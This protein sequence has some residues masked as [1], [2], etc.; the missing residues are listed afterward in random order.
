MQVIP[1]VDVLDGAV[2][3]LERGDFERVTRYS[4]DAVEVAR[5][6]VEEGAEVVHVVDLA[7]ARTGRPSAGLWEA[8]GAANL[9]FQAAG[10]I[11]TAEAARRAL[12]AGAVRIVAGTTAV[13]DDA[14]LGE[15]AAAAGPAL[16]V[17]LDVRDGRAFGAGWEDP[18]REAEVVIRS[19]VQA[20]AARVMVTGIAADGMLSGPD[21]GLLEWAAA[22][23]GVPVIA[24]GGVA[25]LDDIAA[26][27]RVGAEAV[28]IGRALYE[29]RFTLSEALEAAR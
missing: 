20:G 4:A 13:W 25:S 18:G 7:A 11:R 5:G 3:R 29:G 8:L 23:A 16:V 9:P 1:A 21:L 6:F 2:V 14:G 19:A 15:I 17:A 22:T 27:R 26:V 24:S 28:V 12:A 10:G